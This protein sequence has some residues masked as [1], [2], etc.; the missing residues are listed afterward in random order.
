MKQILIH[1]LTEYAFLKVLP[2]KMYNYILLYIKI[3]EMKKIKDKEVARMIK[4]TFIL[5][6]IFLLH[7]NFTSFL[8]PHIQN[9]KKIRTI[10]IKSL[11]LSFS[12]VS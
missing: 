12:M 1:Q 2:Y 8:S 10:R 6:A 9:R 4:I 7:P 11:V 5:A 3:K